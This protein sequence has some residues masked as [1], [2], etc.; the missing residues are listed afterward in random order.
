M[1][2]RGMGNSSAA[3]DTARPLPATS[4]SLHVGS[5]ITMAINHEDQ[6][7]VGARGENT[8]RYFYDENKSDVAFSDLV[9]TPLI[10]PNTKQCW[11][12]RVRA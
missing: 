5:A 10:T 7:A 8:P 9:S 12:S 3:A 4:L 6:T 1:Q 11:S 2:A